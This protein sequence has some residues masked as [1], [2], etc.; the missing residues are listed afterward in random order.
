M[1]RSFVCGSPYH[2]GDRLIA[3]RSGAFERRIEFRRLS[4][5]GREAVVMD[6]IVC[7]ACMV[8]EVAERRGEAGQQTA[9][10]FGEGPR[11]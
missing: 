11:A 4:D 2:V 10:L 6:R 7:R 3:S 9:P 8:A 1:A 5:Q